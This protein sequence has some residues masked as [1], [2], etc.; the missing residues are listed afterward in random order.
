MH[1][2]LILSQFWF[3]FPL[4][5]FISLAFQ[6]TG[7]VCL[8]EDLKMPKI[9]I[10]SNLPPSTFAY[11]PK[12]EP[13]KEKSKEKV[14]TAVLS[15]TSKAKAK[16]KKVQIH[17]IGDTP[18]SALQDAGESSAMDVDKPETKTEE[19]KVEDDKEKEKEEEEKKDEPEA[20][21]EMLTNPARVVPKQL[22]NITYPADCRYAPVRSVCHFWL[23]AHTC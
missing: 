20:D 11:P 7:V 12:T 8:N 4:G 22:G 15:I 23:F 19:K 5:H 6:P 9:D 16:A 18:D 10:M 1:G 17:F 14:K 13:P 3:W 2:C 21:F